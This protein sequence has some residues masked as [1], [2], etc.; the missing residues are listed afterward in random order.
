MGTIAPILGSSKNAS[1]APGAP[2]DALS[3]ALFG[4]ARR[5]ILGLLF[6]R[7]D[8]SFYLR[9]IARLVKGGQGAV[10]RELKRLT[11]AGI[12]TRTIRGRAAFFQ[13]NREC[14]IFSELQGLVLKTA[15]VVGVL[16]AALTPLRD[17]IGVAFVYGS[18]ARVQPKAGSDVDLMVIVSG[19][20]VGS[21][22]FGEVTDALADAQALLGRDVNPTVYDV[23]DFQRR[24]S[25]KDHFLTAVLKEPKL[26]V[27][28][29]EHE[30]EQLARQRLARRPS[31]N[32][33]FSAGP[34]WERLH[35]QDR[36]G[37]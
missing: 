19:G 26:F 29:S 14:P 24:L 12:I 27:M 5:A 32:M 6:S 7:T 15:G 20:P 37:R 4:K 3:A 11:D 8:E 1:H 10:Q 36:S 16:A 25:K 31:S 13:A 9:E 35:H 34:S 2:P 30:L 17:R 28:G 23:R 18:L 21:V 33:V 22:T